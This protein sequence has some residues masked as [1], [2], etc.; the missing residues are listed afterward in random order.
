MQETKEST[1]V[2]HQHTQLEESSKQGEHVLP[3][4]DSAVTGEQAPK[5]SLN[6]EEVA[7][8]PAATMTEEV[9]IHKLFL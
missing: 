3:I 6:E 2:E 4:V 7:D 8:T 1:D 9:K 5:P